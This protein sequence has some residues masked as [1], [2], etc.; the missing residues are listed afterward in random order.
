MNRTPAVNAQLHTEAMSL[1]SDGGFLSALE[2][3][4]GM[5]PG[6]MVSAAGQWPVLAFHIERGQGVVVWALTPGRLVRYEVLEGT[7]LAIAIPLGRV[8]RVLEQISAESVSVT[9][10]L[11]ADGSVI[12]AFSRW[13][14]AGEERSAESV[15][16]VVRTSYV[17]TTTDPAQRGALCEFARVFNGMLGL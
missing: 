13:V 3:A 16:K 15:A 7:S 12:E 4:L 10:E 8:T 9:V 5:P 6:A 11:D 1:S 2:H 17:I 14:A